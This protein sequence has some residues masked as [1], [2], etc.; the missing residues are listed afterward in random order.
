MINDLEAKTKAHPIWFI[1]TIAISAF[2][3]GFGSGKY[4]DDLIAK[5]AGR[6]VITTIELENLR[7]RAELSPDQTTI[8]IDRPATD[9]NRPA[10]LPN[11]ALDKIREMNGVK[12]IDA[13]Q[14]ELDIGRISNGRYGFSSLYSPK[15]S[16]SNSSLTIYAEKNFLLFEVHKATNGSVSIVGFISKADIVRINDKQTKQHSIF[17]FS[18]QRDNSELYSLAS[19][20][21]ASII[22][23][24]LPGSEGQVAE[25][26]LN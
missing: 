1:S 11:T 19:S 22:M 24:N 23:R 17:L 26:T 2:I 20:R 16:F 8:D 18:V 4:L 25:I 6:V 5:T 7:A 13:L 9:I 3:L 10:T 21:I 12:L 15:Q 14:N